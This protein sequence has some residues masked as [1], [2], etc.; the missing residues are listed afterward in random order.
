MGVACRYKVFLYLLE[1]VGE[2][3][4]LYQ[5]FFKVYLFILREKAQVGEGQGERE[6]ER[7]PSR[8]CADSIWPNAGLEPTNWEITT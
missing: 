4:L 8:L 1:G 6:R 7:I 2:S 5:L 3:V